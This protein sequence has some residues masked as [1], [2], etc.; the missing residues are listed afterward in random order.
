MGTILDVLCLASCRE[1]EGR[2]AAPTDKMDRPDRAL[3]VL[4][5]ACNQGAAL[6]YY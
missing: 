1:Q 3:G 5:F 2:W 4:V 6:R